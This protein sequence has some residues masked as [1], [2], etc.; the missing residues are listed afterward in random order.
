[1]YFCIVNKAFIKK[2][3]NV[4]RKVSKCEEQ[5]PDLRAI[6]KLSLVMLI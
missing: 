2:K 1:M 6:Q 4:T 3:K 5:T